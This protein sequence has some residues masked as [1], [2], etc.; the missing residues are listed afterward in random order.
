MGAQDVTHEK[1]CQFAEAA[2]RSPHTV[3][4]DRTAAQSLLQLAGV[5]PDQ[6]SPLHIDAWWVAT[7]DL[8]NATRTYYLRALR[9]YYSWRTKRTGQPDPTAHID[10]LRI[11]ARRPRPVPLTDAMAAVAVA[12]DDTRVMVALC[13]FAGLRVHE[14]AKLRPDDIRTDRDGRRWLYIIGKGQR[15]RHVP[16]TVELDTLLAGYS[17]PDLTPNRVSERVKYALRA[18]TGRRWTAHQLRH[19]FATELLSE[20]ADLIS[21]QRLLGHASVQ[22]TQVYADVSNDRL[23]D[24]IARAFP[25]A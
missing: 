19:T 20:G 2:G 23:H 18:A 3:R 5:T 9:R 4:L 6:A 10:P 8:T 22:T 17:W 16:V 12:T 14:V 24:A 21:L 25:A 11:P 7:A 13:L 1:Y 15:E